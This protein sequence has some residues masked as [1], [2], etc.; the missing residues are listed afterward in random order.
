MIGGIAR[1]GL[2]RE[3]LAS[4]FDPR[5]HVARELKRGQLSSAVADDMNGHPERG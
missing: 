1:A 5:H 2:E 4:A 3:P